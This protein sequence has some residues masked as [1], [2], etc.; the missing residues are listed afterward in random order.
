MV[1]ISNDVFQQLSLANSGGPVCPQ[2]QHLTW[3]SACGWEHAQQFLSPHLVSVVFWHC[4]NDFHVD[5]G[6]DSAISPLPTTQLE[7]LTLGGYPPYTAPIHSALSEVVQRLNTCFKRI[8]VRSSLSDAA[9]GHLASLPKLESLC[10]TDTPSIEVLKSIHRNLT[11]PALGRMVL[12]LNG[13]YQ[14]LPVLFSLLK[15]SSLEEVVVKESPKIRHVGVPT[16]VAFAI[17]KAELHRNLNT[18]AFTGF[19]PAGLTSISHLGPFGALKTLRCSTRCQEFQQCVFPLRDSDIEQL[20]SGLPQLENLCLGHKC[21]YNHPNTT[22]KSMIALSAHCPSLAAL[23]LP[24]N[25]TNISEDAKMESGEPD[26]RLN[27]RSSCPLEFLAFEWMIRPKDHEASRI[28]KSALRHLF[29]R[30]RFT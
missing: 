15:S 28:M 12:E 20:A 18:L 4:T 25:L 8:D 1:A 30:L 11:F 17:L 9:W 19:H 2:L 6:L 3:T 5:L 23:Y 21:I 13:Q 26:P 24:C 29:P 22:I 14:H 10:V 27:T 7:K 16:E